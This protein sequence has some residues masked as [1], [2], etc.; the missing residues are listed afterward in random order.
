MSAVALVAGFNGGARRIA[1]PVA[2][3][4]TAHAR[5]SIGKA[6]RI[7]RDPTGYTSEVYLESIESTMADIM[8]VAPSFIVMQYIKGHLDSTQ[9]AS[10]P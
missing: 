8:N 6:R 4:I 2:L 7:R 1:P 9:L 5:A 3:Q 10:D